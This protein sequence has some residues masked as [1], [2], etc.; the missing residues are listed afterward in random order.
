[1]PRGR[2]PRRCSSSTPTQVLERVERDGDLFAPVLVARAGAARAVDAPSGSFAATARRAAAGE[3]GACS[4]RRERKVTSPGSPVGADRALRDVEVPGEQRAAVAPDGGARRRRGPRRGRRP[5][6]SRRSRSAASSRLVG[7]AR[8]EVGDVVDARGD[9]R[10]A[11]ATATAAATSARAAASGR[12][13]A[14]ER[15]AGHARGA[16]RPAARSAPRRRS[17]AWL[18]SR[19]E[20]DPRRA[21][22]PRGARRPARASAASAARDEERPRARRAS[23]S[24]DGTSAVAGWPG[25]GIRARSVERSSSPDAEHSGTNHGRGD[26]DGERGERGRSAAS[27]RQQPQRRRAARNGQASGR[28]S[29]AS[30]AERERLAVAARRAR[31]RTRRATSATSSGSASPTAAWRTKPPVSSDAARRGEQPADEPTP[32]G[33]G[34]R[35]TRA[36]TAA[37]APARAPRRATARARRRRTGARSAVTATGSGFHAGPSAVL[38]APSHSSRPQSSHAQAS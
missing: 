38:S 22:R 2:R 8:A 14:R 25:F 17:P 15:A 23:V 24:S 4:V 13:A 26:R 28:T 32:E 34:R 16:P 6:R 7:E 1:M 19:D 18:I 9:A 27:S 31:A 21:A 12:G 3:S 5:R 37:S 30:G 10:R 20:E 36:S 29:A 35:R 11:R 33:A